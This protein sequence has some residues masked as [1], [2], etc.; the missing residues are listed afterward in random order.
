MKRQDALLSI[1]VDLTAS[2]AS[3]HRLSRLLDA[4]RRAIPCDAAAVLRLDGDE[5][6]PVATH[7]LAPEV[8]GLPFPRREHPRLDVAVAQAEPVIFP[9]DSALPDPYDGHLSATPDGRCTVHSC[10]GCPLLEGGS[11]VGLLTADA[12]E[13][14]AFDNLDMEFLRMLGAL[15]GAAL[16]TGR[17]IEALERAA[18]R[19][20]QVARDLQ[21]DASTRG[22]SQILGTSAPIRRVLE[23]VSVVARSDFAVLITGETGVGKELVARALHQASDRRDEP[24]I[25]VN[26]AALPEAIVESELFGHVRGAFTGASADRSGKFELADKGTLF[27]DE[28]GELP[29]SVQPKLLRVLQEGEIQRVGSDAA[30]RVDARIVAATNRD[31]QREVDAGKFRADLF[32]RLNM[33]PI[34]VPPLRDRR[35]DIPLLAGHFLDLY[36]RKLGL[37][38]VRLTSEARAA[39]VA[40]RWPGNVRELDHLL[41][42]AVLRASAGDT[43][44]SPILIEVEHL[45]V[46]QTVV[47]TPSAG[48]DQAGEAAVE[49]RGRPLS[50]AVEEFKRTMIRS[51]VA[52]HSGNWAAAARSL[53]MARGN[54]HHMARRLGLRDGE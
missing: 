4:L 21:R 25:Y 43:A 23:D 24:L 27:L 51:A 3:P 40:A 29:L 15:A 37:A 53:G 13:P 41:G 26:C 6:I 12:V 49:F 34:C 9:A 2:L 20:Q 7:G 47:T 1:A 50:E 16:R 5:L 46:D 11:V 17:L 54:L 39:L 19:H 30:L 10:L 35:T 44:G 42:R 31:L 33:Y 32:H 28:V 14:G 22:G 45:Q 36:R 48:D 18:D 8:L 38:P 52:E